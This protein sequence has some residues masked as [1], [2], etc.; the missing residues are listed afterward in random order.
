[1]RDVTI[2]R[3]GLLIGSAGGI[4]LA[5]RPA[6]G[7]RQAPL[8]PADIDTIA[9]GF[10]DGL[11]MAGVA[12]TV[13]QPGAPDIARGY[14][15]RTLGK[16]DP[17]DGH[18]LFAI[19]SNSKAFTAAALAILVDEGRI[20][21]DQPVVGY[22]PEFAMYDP[23]V[24]QMMTVRDLLVHR[25]GLGLG[26]GDLML[27][28]GNHSIA[29][30]VHGL[31]YLKPAR[32]FRAG[33]AYDNILYLVAGLLIER[34]S[35]QSW[36]DFVTARLLVPLGMGETVTVESLSTS[37]NIAGRHARLGPPVR[38]MGKL[39]VVVAQNDPRIGPAGGIMAS[40]HDIAAWLHAQL[41]HGETARGRRLWS[42]KQATE[43]WQPQ[44]ITTYTDG[45]TA[46]D[47]GRAV[48]AAYALGWNVQDYRGHRLISHTGLLSGQST[49][50]AMLPEQGVAI[51]IYT[52][53]E[54]RLVTLGLR[55]ALL[56]R[57]LGVSGS[58]WIALTQSRLDKQEREALA[59]IG[60]GRFEAPPGRLSLP[61]AAYVGRYR[62]PW[63]GDII[64][65]QTGQTLSLDMT[66][67]LTG[68]SLLERWGTDAF[69]THFE[70]DSEDAVVSFAVKDG[71][72]AGVT[73][74]ALS[75]LADFSFDYQD[76]AFVPVAEG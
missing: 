71:R 24:T 51:A 56:D 42:E 74:K 29:E 40:A 73:M 13:V 72:V 65:T 63:Y 16:P 20:G 35:G 38:G 34:V 58:D 47:P 5:A 9:R 37:A 23:A 62:D 57:L 17:V 32:G 11:P 43:M 26:Q 21:W 52:N 18:T 68:E 48:M 61:L 33:Y 70:G 14:G 44:V 45:P 12:I 69:R 60:G 49:A 50:Q 53:Q 41:A 19:A 67:T 10:L 76:L 27:F 25:S 28:G 4:A 3:R 22:L 75:P 30:M 8:T 54:E 46:A 64:V 36:A 15:V 59:A 66:R 39:G 6:W 1:M 31:R 7:Q 2:S 55:N